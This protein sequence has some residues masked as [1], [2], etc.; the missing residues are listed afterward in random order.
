[1]AVR[2]LL[3]WL[4]AWTSLCTAS[5]PVDDPLSYGSGVLVG[6]T[7][8]RI[9]WTLDGQAFMAGL[10]DGLFNEKLRIPG[11]QLKQASTDL[12]SVRAKTPKALDWPSQGPY[13]IDVSSSKARM[14]YAVGMQ[15]GYEYSVV[16]R[17]LDVKM[18]KQ[19]IVDVLSRSDRFTKPEFTKLAEKGAAEFARIAAAENKTK[20]QSFLEWNAQ[21]SS[22]LRT[23]SGLQYEILDA[24]TGPSAAD[25]KWVSV[26]FSG[27]VAHGRKLWS[28]YEKGEP[29]RW[30]VKDLIVG[31]QELVRLSRVGT[32]VRAWVPS[33]LAYGVEGARQIGPN[34]TLEVELTLIKL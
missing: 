5:E 18:F 25:A 32:H 15:F 16:V 21:R 33:D 28:T 4:L 2:L 3:C 6:R 13:S 27:R 22:V 17:H 8:E 24:G 30:R 26:H 9:A 31:M 10:E 11:D 12:T 34:E 29:V 7:M 14:G 1:M 20:Q 19:G 23:Q